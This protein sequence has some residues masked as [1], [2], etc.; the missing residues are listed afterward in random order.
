L[1]KILGPGSITYAIVVF[2]AIYRWL[3]EEEPEPRRRRY[4]PRLRT[5]W[6]TSAAAN[7]HRNNAR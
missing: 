3:D 5:A 6:V 7:G 2:W 1:Q 4:E